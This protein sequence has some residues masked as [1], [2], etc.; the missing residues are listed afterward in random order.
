MRPEDW[1]AELERAAAGGLRRRL[2]VPDGRGEGNDA[3]GI[4]LG[5]N[6]YLGLRRH[7]RLAAAAISAI[8]DAGTGAGASRLLRG[9]LSVHLE[10]EAALAE[11]KRTEAT[12]VF[13]SGYAAN[14]GLLSVLGSSE[15][16][17]L[18]LDRLDHASL[19]DGARLARARVYFYD[20]RDLDRLDRQLQRTPAKGARWIVTDGVFSMDGTLAPLPELVA[21]ARRHRAGLVIDDA[22]A[23]GVVGPGGA[24]T[25]AH[26]GI[27]PS[28]E[29]VQMGTLSKA[30]GSQGGYVAGSRALIDL[31]VQRSRSFVYSTGLAPAA[32]AAAQEALRVIADEPERGARLQRHQQALREGLRRRGWRVLGEAPAP[33][34]AVQV[35]EPEDAVALSERLRA[36]GVLAPAVRPPTVPRGTSRVRLAARA[37]MSEE[38]VERVVEAFG[39]VG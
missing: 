11:L 7:P 25:L 32:A 12:L 6:D 10:L 35:G 9:N 36:R 31:L 16:D 21:L 30:L 15:D 24:G 26:F 8:E 19:V 4:D 29:I 20:A 3:A 38:I 5:T 34:L 2:P 33:M 22:H 13:S 23:T 14:L 28:E 37:D 39:A 18:F 1:S 27:E 17:T